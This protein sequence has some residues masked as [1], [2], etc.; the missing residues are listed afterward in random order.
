MKKEAK[1]KSIGSFIPIKRVSNFESIDKFNLTE[2]FIKNKVGFVSKAIKS[3]DESCITFCM[4][5]IKSLK[6][7]YNLIDSNIRLVTVVTQNPDTRIP[8]SSAIVHNIMKLDKSCM[9]FDISQGCSGFV[10]ALIITK[11]L[12]ESFDNGDALIL[13]SDQYSDIINHNSKNESLIFGDAAAATLL[14][15]EGPGYK[16][17]DSNFGTSPNSNDCLKMTSSNYLEMNGSEVFSSV[18]EHV[19]PSIEQLLSNNNNVAIHDINLFLLH[20]GSKYV[21]DSIRRYFSIPNE[22]MPFDSKDY[23]NTISSSIPILLEKNYNP[24]KYPYILLS[25]FGVGFTWGNAIIRYT[26]S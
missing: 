26:E 10:H 21:V 14:S 25:G 2:D 23:G 8:H 9:T 3:P 19:V 18:M 15:L 6:K 24:K 20:Q 1:I 7:K 5:A 11:N 16:V 13:T 22:I 12:L 17:I 4:K